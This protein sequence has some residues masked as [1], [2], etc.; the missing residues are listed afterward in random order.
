MSTKITFI[1]LDGDAELEAMLR[2]AASSDGEPTGTDGVVINIQSLEATWNITSEKWDIELIVK[3]LASD[4][5]LWTHWH[6]AINSTFSESG[7]AGGYM[8]LGGGLIKVISSVSPGAYSFAVVAVNG[9]HEAASNVDVTTVLLPVD[10][11]ATVITDA[12]GIDGEETVSVNLLSLADEL[13]IDK[14]DLVEAIVASTSVDTEVTSGTPLVGGKTYYK[15][16]ETIVTSQVANAWFGGERNQPSS[17]G[18]PSNDPKVIGIVHDG[19]LSLDGHAEKIML[20]TSANIRGKLPHVNLSAQGDIDGPAVFKANVK[21]W[22]AS[23]YVGKA[24]P[25]IDAST[26]EYYLDLSLLRAE[27]EDMSGGAFEEYPDFST[28]LFEEISSVQSEITLTDGLSFP[29]SGYVKIEEEFILYTGKTGDDILTGCVRGILPSAAPT[30]HSEGTVVRSIPDVIKTVHEKYTDIVISANVDERLDFVFGSSSPEFSA[31]TFTHRNRFLFDKHNAAFRAGTVT[32][33]YWNAAHRGIASAAFGYN[34]VAKGDATFV[35]G[36]FNYAE[37]PGS[38]VMGFG[39]SIWEGDEESSTTSL[40]VASS[41]NTITGGEYNDIYNGYGSGALSGAINWVDFSR[42]SAIVSGEKNWIRGS[43]DER[44]NYSF[45]GSGYQNIINFSNGSGIVAGDEN[46][47]GGESTGSF[48][49]AGE[50][51][52]ILTNE[53]AT[54]SSGLKNV[55]KNRDKLIENSP[56]APGVLADRWTCEDDDGYGRS[57]RR[58]KMKDSGSSYFGTSFNSVIG[59]GKENTIVNADQSFV[60]GGDENIISVSRSS[61]ILGGENN[62]IEPYIIITGPFGTGF[63]RS[64][65]ISPSYVSA[66]VGGRDNFIMA[67]ASASTIV[68]GVANTIVESEV[69]LLFGKDNASRKTPTTEVVTRFTHTT[70]YAAKSNLYGQHAHASG[71]FYSAGGS[72]SKSGAKYVKHT[73]S[74]T[75]KLMGYEDLSKT[76]GFLRTKDASSDVLLQKVINQDAKDISDEREFAEQVGSKK[77]DIIKAGQAKYISKVMESDPDPTTESIWSSNSDMH[78]GSAQT[79]VL[80]LRREVTFGDFLTQINPPMLFGEET[81]KVGYGFQEVKTFST[82]NSGPKFL[83]FTRTLDRDEKGSHESKTFD[84][85]YHSPSSYLSDS[86][87]NGLPLTADYSSRGSVS[88][89]PRQSA[90][91]QWLQISDVHL[92]RAY[93]IPAVGFSSFTWD[94]LERLLSWTESMFPAHHGVTGGVRSNGGLNFEKVLKGLIPSASDPYGNPISSHTGVPIKRITN[95]W[96]GGFS[97]LTG[98]PDLSEDGLSGIVDG[99]TLTD[100]TISLGDDL[101]L[102]PVGKGTIISKLSGAGDEYATPLTIIITEDMFDA[103]AAG[104]DGYFYSANSD[105]TYTFYYRCIDMKYDLGKGYPS[106]ADFEAMDRVRVGTALQAQSDQVRTADTFEIMEIGQGYNIDKFYIPF[107]NEVEDEEDITNSSEFELFLSDP[108]FAQV[109]EVEPFSVW[110]F[111]ITAVVTTHNTSYDD[112]TMHTAFGGNRGMLRTA[113]MKACGG[114]SYPGLHSGE[115]G[116]TIDLT[117]AVVF[118]NDENGFDKTTY[119]DGAPSSG[120]N[121]PI[122]VSGTSGNYMDNYMDNDDDAGFYLKVDAGSTAIP[123][124]AMSFA[125]SHKDYLRLIIGT[126]HPCRVVA[127][128]ELTQISGIESFVEDYELVYLK[129]Q[130]EKVAGGKTPTSV[131]EK[132]IDEINDSTILE[133]EDFDIQEASVIAKGKQFADLTSKEL[134]KIVTI[135]DAT[136]GALITSDIEYDVLTV[137]SVNDSIEQYGLDTVTQKEL[138]TASLESATLGTSMDTSIDKVSQ[139]ISAEIDASVEA[140]GVDLKTDASLNAYLD[141]KNTKLY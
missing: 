73:S 52:N 134:K 14:E 95:A 138:E 124:G 82:S 67:D 18:L 88:G 9:D 17:I 35:A 44:V 66:I 77:S 70:G 112:A 117:S 100:R 51:N 32:G 22:P 121:S 115:Y 34:G 104:E 89:L 13:G 33:T 29:D 42:S 141:N 131:I 30:E 55:L 58:K 118:S 48:I 120:V 99:V 61:S 116:D 126:R 71:G 56:F 54:T 84:S 12:L 133:I 59:G 57:E 45:I 72:T 74:Q 68:G 93:K 27:L 123:F 86:Q 105:G 75:R 83:I 63:H 38:V 102:H 1:G 125:P 37:T 128:V 139:D 97:P 16:A 40:G 65:S 108:E 21:T 41:S 60:G 23:E 28:T 91:F 46:I 5:S 76:S 62:S 137:D 111:S 79:S 96:N 6:Y 92:N 113:V 47:I 94:W 140:L 31:D 130:E 2:D 78:I 3:I 122:M 7:A 135:V 81:E 87:G 4:D 25:E 19:S 49:G 50:N 85:W 132:A 109:L 107:E 15:N 11:S 127:R 129:S 80:T 43:C 136:K 119:S 103:A 10:G 110:A 101:I 106:E 53:D 114:I 90:E 20:T 64:F 69:G 36:A 24:I 98:L 26:G 8:V 39:S